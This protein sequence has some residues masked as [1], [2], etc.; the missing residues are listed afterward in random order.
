MKEHGEIRQDKATRQWVIYAPARRKRPKDFKSETSSVPLLPEHARD[1]PFCPGNE[2]SLPPVILELGRTGTQWQTRVVPNKFPALDPRGRLSRQKTGIFITM[3]GFGHHEV[4]I[5]TPF[6]NR[7]LAVMSGPEVAAVIETYHRRYTDLM[8]KNG[9]MMA[10]IFRN[11][12][13]RA[14]TSLVHPHSQII[15][16]GI[17]PNSIRWRE[18]EAQRYYDEWGTCVFCDI[19]DYELRDHSRIVYQN[20]SFAVFVPFAAEVP[21]ELWIMT[22]RHEADFLTI[23]DEE[24]EDLADALRHALGRLRETLH[25][26]DYN[27]ALNTWARYRAQEPQLHWYLQIRPRLMTPA[28][29]EIGSGMSINPSIPEEDAAFLRSAP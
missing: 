10:I 11:H 4:V 16:T 21:F 24:K 29:F 20:G 6:H 27:Y 1:C 22:R 18:E 26:P 7:D 19:L 13:E 23:S 15:A 25:D 5:E 2:E 14:G 17:V 8:G 3:E 28:G 9:I 12:G